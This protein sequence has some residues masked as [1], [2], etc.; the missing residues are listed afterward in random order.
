MC[1]KMKFTD[2][3]FHKHVFALTRE[4]GVQI[5]FPYSKF[6]FLTADPNTFKLRLEIKKHGAFYKDY[7]SFEKMKNDADRLSGKGKL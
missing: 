3:Q 2:I 7:P 1:S 6:D 5:Y 4:D